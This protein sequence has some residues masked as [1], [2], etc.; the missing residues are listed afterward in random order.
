MRA[1]QLEVVI[2]AKTDQFD[3][4]MAGVDAK[5]KQ[6]AQS[7]NRA[8]AETSSAARKIKQSNSVIKESVESVSSEIIES[9]GVDGDVA[10]MLANSLVNVKNA[11]VI[12]GIGATAAVAL[13]GAGFVAAAS[14]AA[15]LGDQINDLRQQT[16]I[17]AETL[18]GLGAAAKLEGK[19]L[20]DLSGTL[21]EFSGKLTEARAGND[22]LQKTFKALGVDIKGGPDQALRQVITRL[23][24]YKD[25]AAKTALAQKVFGDSGKDLIPILNSMEGGI[26]GAIAKAKELGLFFDTEGA[27]AAAR[28][29]DQMKQLS[30]QFDGLVVRIGNAVIPAFTGFT[31][32]INEAWSATNRLASGQQSLKGW[33]AQVAAIGL[34]AQNPVLLGNLGGGSSGGP[35]RS[36]RAEA[37]GGKKDAPIIPTGGG[38]KAR[39]KEITEL[40]QLQKQLKEL[41]KDI[42]AFGNLTSQEFRV[43]MEVEQAREFK[44][45]LEEI[46][47][48][49][50]ELGQPVA[51]AF[52]STS[53]AAQ[54]E[55]DQLNAL[56]RAHEALAKTDWQA[57]IR[58]SMEARAQE[59]GKALESFDEVT[60]ELRSRTGDEVENVGAELGERFAEAMAQAIKFGRPDIVAAINEIVEGAK[61]DAAI[62]RDTQ[63]A[64]TNTDVAFSDLERQRAAIQNELNRGIITEIQARDRQIQVEKE[65]RDAIIAALEAEK[66]LAI[67]RGDS[68]EAARLAAEIEKTQGL[69]EAIDLRVQG[70]KDQLGRD[71]DGL[72]DALIEGG[73]RWMDAA[74]NIGVNFFNT[75]AS[76]MMLAATGGKYGSLGGLLG[77]L[78]GNLLGGLFGGFGGG[79]GGSNAF[80]LGPTGFLASGGPVNAGGAYVVGEEG[81]ELFVPRSSGR[82]VPND[83]MMGGQQITVINNFNI[84]AP[85][86]RVAPE[87]QAQI[88]AKVGQGIQAAMQRNG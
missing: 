63:R 40:Q 36:A 28:Y 11:A 87:T 74:R 88:A 48:L 53:E 33:L 60:R 25:G 2:T 76:E 67:A 10:N 21:T 84:S 45:R 34:A 71:F 65:A 66:A 85:G 57:P 31:R 6:A 12:M 41:N 15:E 82:V 68:A 35:K 30:A 27:A 7:L 79:G 13:V 29:E 26:D 38:S 1:G 83:Q 8:A 19:S 72:I 42:S 32:V 44:S 55:I 49:R 24:E 54:R 56:K 59:F 22:E 39:A 23:S 3:R 70:L 43:R 69:G 47:K 78:A 20:S 61:R 58:A 73:D 50:R 52:P 16:G 64:R 62:A 77:G 37:M 51:V 86:G 75:L 17:A 80:G 18:S 46:L 14:H 4:A 5:G 81:P 9:F